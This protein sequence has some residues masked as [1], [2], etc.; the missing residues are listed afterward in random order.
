MIA[1]IDAGCP[2][3]RIK[4]IN[5]SLECLKPVQT[6]TEHTEDTS[7]EIDRLKGLV[8]K[9]SAVIISRNEETHVKKTLESILNQSIK[10][11]KVVVVDDGSTDATLEI[12]NSMRVAVI[13][14]PDHDKKGAVYSD[15]LGEVR[16]VG[17]ANVR[18]D[19]INW[20]YSGDADTVLPPRYCENMMK[21]AGEN[22]A[23]V[24]SGTTDEESYNLPM[25]SC[26][27][28]KHDWFRDNGMETKWG[29]I[30]L[31]MLTLAQGKNTLVRHAS[32]CIVT[33]QRPVG[34]RYVSDRLYN[35]GRLVRRMGLPLYFLFWITAITARKNGLTAGW[36]VFKGGLG[37]KQRVPK[38]VSEIYTT[39]I[40]E[41][42]L[43]RRFRY[44]KR[45]HRMRDETDGN[46]VY[47]PPTNPTKQGS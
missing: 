11:Y 7:V 30:Y 47:H 10:P 17:F 28:I 15:T 6:R 5:D 2:Q 13:K 1:V 20:V 9:Y 44:F 19:P 29:S 31:T 4:T 34:L 18:D 8:P 41:D 26:R 37:E 12:L 3:S 16:N 32:D 22:N 40:K 36:L 14:R 38:E 24:A 46:V 35:Y 39:M 42:F 23:C 27:M 33:A 45:R 21:Y 25:D 43:C